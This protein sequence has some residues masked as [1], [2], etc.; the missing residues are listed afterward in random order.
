MET[1]VVAEVAP[2]LD[3]MAGVL[4]RSQSSADAHFSQR[5]GVERRTNGMV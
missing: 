3:D 4:R 2:V 1:P 5:C